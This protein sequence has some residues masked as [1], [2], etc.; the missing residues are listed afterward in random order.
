MADILGNPGERLQRA[1]GML[2]LAI[3]VVGAILVAGRT[4][5]GNG[6]IVEARILRFERYATDLGEM[7]LVVVQLADGSVRQ[8]PAR[9]NAIGGCKRGSAISLLRNGSALSVGPK[10]CT[11]VTL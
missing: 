7:P 11:D 10:G 6:E 9:R 1:F 2:L 4:H 8:V 3:L 5:S